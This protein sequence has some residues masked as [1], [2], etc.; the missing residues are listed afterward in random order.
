MLCFYSGFSGFSLFHIEAQKAEQEAVR[1]P[2]ENYIKGHETGNPEFM[3]K[4]FYTESKLVFMRDGKFATRTFDEYIGGMSRKPAADESK[5]Q[6]RIE[7]V[8]IAG[9]A[10]SAKIILDYPTTKFTDYMA[11]LKIDG[12]WEIVNKTFY[13]EPKQSPEGE[14]KSE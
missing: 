12:E 6:R 3:R 8:D 10:A 2:L 5:R 9:N 13:V 4:A 14:K 1:I 11:L 7:S